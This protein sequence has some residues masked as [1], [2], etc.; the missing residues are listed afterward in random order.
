MLREPNAASNVAA[1]NTSNA[2]ATAAN[3]APPKEDKVNKGKR[4][5]GNGDFFYS[6]TNNL[7]SDNS[8]DMAVSVD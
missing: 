8:S 7:D 2:A 6:A 5:K 3:V 1:N 4:N